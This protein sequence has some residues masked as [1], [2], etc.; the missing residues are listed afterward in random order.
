MNSSMCSL[1]CTSLCCWKLEKFQQVFTE[2]FP[3]NCN[4]RYVIGVITMTR[5]VAAKEA[6]EKQLKKREGAPFLWSLL[7]RV[8]FN[9]FQLELC[10]SFAFIHASYCNIGESMF[11]IRNGGSR[12]LWSES[13]TIRSCILHLAKL[14]RSMICVV[15]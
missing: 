10:S 9:V 13:Q 14:A 5:A 15:L 1:K 7:V 8:Q 2:L 12:Q 4:N 6:I 3:D 11:D